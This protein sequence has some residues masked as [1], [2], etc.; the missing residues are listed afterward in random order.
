MSSSFCDRENIIMR[1]RR[2]RNEEK[3]KK[4]KMRKIKEKTRKS[5][6]GSKR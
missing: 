5:G 1:N 6:I 4:D 3:D 2:R